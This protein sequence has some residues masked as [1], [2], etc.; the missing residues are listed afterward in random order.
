VLA[1][2]RRLL[3]IAVPAAVVFLALSF[4]IA[5]FLTTENRERSRIYALL[6]AEADGDPAAVL[7]RLEGCNAACAAKV[8]A[9]LPRLA[10]PGEVKIARLDSGTSYSL[11]TAEGLSRVV[12]VR[13]VT[14]RPVVQCVLVRRSG[15]PLTGRSVSLLR[16]TAPLADNEDPC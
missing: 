13:G 4:A 7:D 9:F 12:W 15:D 3:L 14:A 8:R 16:V 10:G 5:R 11:G 1:R 2:R 6:R